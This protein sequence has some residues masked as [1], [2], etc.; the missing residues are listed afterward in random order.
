L[1]DTRKTLTDAQI[2]KIMGKL[3]RTFE[4]E[5]GAELR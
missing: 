5:L 2:D 1:Q 3:Q 4:K